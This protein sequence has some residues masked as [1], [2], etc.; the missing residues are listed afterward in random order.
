MPWYPRDF[1][2]STRGWPLAA[3]ALYRELLDAQWD[4]G[5]LPADDK[6]L[7]KLAG[8]SLK[9]WR[10]SWRFVVEKF[11]ICS[12]GKRRNARLETH[13]SKELERIEKRRKAAND[14][15]DAKRGGNANASADGMQMHDA[16]AP[17][18][19]MLPSPR[20]IPV[21][22]KKEDS[23]LANARGAPVAG[24][25]PV[26]RDE[27]KLDGA[28]PKRNGIDSAMHR[29]VVELY[30]DVVRDLPRVKVWN[31]QRRRKLEARIRETIKRGK[32]ADTAEW[33]QRFFETVASSDFLCGRKTA[34]RCPGLEWLLEPKNF[35]K[36]IEGA[37]DNRPRSERRA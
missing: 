20:P 17:V 29:Q 8:I 4:L 14:R 2:S 19:H 6:T 31:E 30:H 27:L 13:R 12:D 18:L 16:H 25:T 10:V 28:R 7:R 1:A 9:D 15:W 11:S 3:R 36:V 26:D 32:P 24:A 21:E 35:T 22:E 37:Y 23:P 5:G 33:W 34:W